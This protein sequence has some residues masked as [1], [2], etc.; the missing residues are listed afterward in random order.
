MWAEQRGLALAF[1]E[2]GRPNQNAYIERLNCAFRH[3]DFDVWVFTS[4][5]EVRAASEEW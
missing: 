2:A 3:E 1:I 5:A 4:L